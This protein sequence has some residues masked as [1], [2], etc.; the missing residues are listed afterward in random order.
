LEL[1]PLPG[2][3]GPD[4]AARGATNQG[5]RARWGTLL[6]G[7]VLRDL[8]PE[9]LWSGLEVG[10]QACLHPQAEGSTNKK[11]CWHE[12]HLIAPR[13]EG[14]CER[15]SRAKQRG[16]ELILRSAFSWSDLAYDMSR[17]NRHPSVPE[18]E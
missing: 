18:N 8:L 17:T 5:H 9:L 3:K 15:P 4:Y 14:R 2:G 13:A 10:G 11:P 6:V 12:F 16:V 1:V 7:E